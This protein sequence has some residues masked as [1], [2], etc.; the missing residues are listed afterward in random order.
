MS[1]REAI[2]AAVGAVTGQPSNRIQRPTGP[3]HKITRKPKTKAFK[4]K[5]RKAE[6]ARRMRLKTR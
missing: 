6:H 5:K 2:A 4:R 1:M 3:G